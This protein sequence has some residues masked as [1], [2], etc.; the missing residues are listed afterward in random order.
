M[1]AHARLS[2]SHAIVFT[3]DHA[4]KIWNILDERIGEV[5]ASAT[6]ADGLTRHF[7]NLE[8]LTQY[9]NSRAKAIQ[10]ITFDARSREPRKSA[11][12]GG[13]ALGSVDFRADGE[14]QVVS[15]L[16]EFIATQL[17]GMRPW[18]SP[19]AQYGLLTLW[20]IV[21]IFSSGN[22]LVGGLKGAAVFN[23]QVLYALFCLGILAAVAMAWASDYLVKLKNAVYPIVAFS[24]GQGVGRF[25]TAENLRWVVVVGFLVSIA[26]SVVFALVAP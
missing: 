19:I 12:L 7:A 25:Q 20:L 22:L 3:V 16:R 24:I 8:Q 13:F 21:A 6:C 14:E 5:G 4:K 2:L 15:R 26:A 1:E 17:D 11:T 10:S 23:A 9:E 18:Y